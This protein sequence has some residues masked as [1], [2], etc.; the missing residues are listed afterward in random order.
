MNKTKKNTAELNEY[1]TEDRIENYLTY[2][3][4]ITPSLNKRTGYR[5]IQSNANPNFAP[6]TLSIVL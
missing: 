3:A 1:L 6:L 4:F 5:I 2:S